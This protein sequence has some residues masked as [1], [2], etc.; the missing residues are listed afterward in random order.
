VLV[1]SNALAYPLPCAYSTVVREVEDTTRVQSGKNRRKWTLR[2]ITVVA[3]VIALLAIFSP[4][5]FTVH[6]G[7]AVGLNAS[8]NATTIEQNQSVRVSLS[9]TNFLP[10]ANAASGSSLQSRNLSA[11]PCQGTYPMGITLYQGR[12]TEKNISVGSPLQFFAPGTY[13]CPAATG[14]RNLAPFWTFSSH[15]N[16][17]GYWTGGQTPQSGGVW[18]GVYHQFLPGEYTV[19]VGDAWGHTTMLH[20]RVNGIALQDFSLCASNCGY[21][22][23]YLSGYI[24][25]GG[26]SPLQ[27]LRLFVD[28]TNG[29]VQNYTS[30]GITNF[31]MLYKGGFASPPVVSGEVYSL[32]FVAT[33]QDGSTAAAATTVTAE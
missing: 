3:V 26:S 7:W 28:G 11:G 10:L 20:F 31:V 1:E 12:F 15:V 24:Y 6:S 18:E 29:G 9:V 30:S 13:S 14:P 4:L 2:V 19:V 32:E 27:S 25:F 5:L 21:P 23:P 17:V 8:L 22:S 16:L 33:F